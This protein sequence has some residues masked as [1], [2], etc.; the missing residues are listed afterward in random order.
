MCM[1]I[2][3]KIIVY[4]AFGLLIIGIVGAIFASSFNKSAVP[5]ADQNAVQA[6]ASAPVPAGSGDTLNEPL[7]PGVPTG[8]DVDQ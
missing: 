3:S 2:N 4:V 6:P 7:P 8:T 1:N 5:S